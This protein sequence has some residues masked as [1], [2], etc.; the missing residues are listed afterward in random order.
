MTKRLKFWGW[1]YEDDVVP[2]AEIRWMEETWGKRFGV[3][4]YFVVSVELLEP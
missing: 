4:T 1:G 3:P 2:E